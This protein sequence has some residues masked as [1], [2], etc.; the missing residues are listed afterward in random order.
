MAATD[1]MLGNGAGVRGGATLKR[2]VVEGSSGCKDGEVGDDLRRRLVRV[3]GSKSI[4]SSS[5]FCSY[6]LSS[7]DSISW[8][9]TEN[10]TPDA[11]TC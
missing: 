7:S 8:S 11:W 6:C 1:A 4:S 2:C 5:S 3:A 9:W 10:M